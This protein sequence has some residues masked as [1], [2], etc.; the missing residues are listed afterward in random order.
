MDEVA[1]PLYLNSAGGINHPAFHY[2]RSDIIFVGEAVFNA[3][4]ANKG[5]KVK[6]KNRK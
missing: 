4:G 2:P 1:I 3:K 6:K 5:R